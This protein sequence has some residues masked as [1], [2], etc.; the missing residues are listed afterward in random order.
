MRKQGCFEQEE[1]RNRLLGP[2]LHGF[3][4]GHLAQLM[5]RKQNSLWPVN[6]KQPIVGSPRWQ[7]RCLEQAAPKLEG[8]EKDHI[9]GWCCISGTLDHVGFL[10]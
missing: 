8:R 2:F 1:H 7:C 3:F 10:L 6:G 9:E 4:D 5:V